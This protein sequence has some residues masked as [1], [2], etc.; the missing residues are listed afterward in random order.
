MSV[1][2]KCHPLDRL[3]VRTT[4][5]VLAFLVVGATL[6]KPAATAPSEGGTPRVPVVVELFTS[7]GCSSCPPA[8]ELLMRLE[9]TQPVAGAEIL[10]LGE[11]VD[12]WDHLGW[13]DSFSSGEFSRRQST[14]DE[15]VFHRGSIYT[16]QMVVDGRE[17]LLGSDADA[18]LAAVKKAV[19]RTQP[20]VGVSLD[21]KRD[22]D[23]IVVSVR[24]AASSQARLSGDAE[25]L[26]ALT[27]DGVESSVR[28][29]EN[30][31]RRLRHGGVVR[32]LESMGRLRAGEERWDGTSRLALPGKE[33]SGLFRI[34][35]FVQET[36]SRRIVGAASAPL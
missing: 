6:V 30:S 23:V 24:V 20:R 19:G 25:V 12:Y 35:A 10:A 1:F 34:V 16:P 5:R 13:R 17:E 11:H 4:G 15:Q 22:A 29:G 9:T 31:G 26:V 7:E 8:D 18:A 32:S 27:Q 14:Y 3:P 28:A 21:L 2:A 33:S 36:Q